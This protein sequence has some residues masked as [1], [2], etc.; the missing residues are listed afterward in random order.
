MSEAVFREITKADKDLLLEGACQLPKALAQMGFTELRKGQEDPIMSILA[1][2][3]T[4]CI[5]PTGTGK[6]A[7]F[8]IPSLCHEWPT[9]VLSPLVALMRDQVKSLWAKGIAGGALSGIQTPAENASTLKAWMDGEVQFLYVAP[10]RL[11]NEQFRQA[12][13]ARPPVHVVVDEAHTIT[14]W[15]DN[16]RPAY[17]KAGDFISEHNPRVVSAFTATCPAEVEVDIR[18]VL[19]IPNAKRCMY[20]PRRTNLKLSS[21]EFTGIPQIARLIEKTDGCGI[22]YCSSIKNVEDTAVALQ[23]LLDEDVTLFHAQLP[24]NVRRTNQDLFM[25]GKAKVVVA[26]NAFGMGI[27]KPD[28]RFVIHRDIPGSLESL[29]Q[30]VGRAGR[31]GK[32][33]WCCTLMSAQGRRIQEYFLDG[34]NPDKDTITKVYNVLKSRA[35]GGGKVMLTIEEIGKIAGVNSM[36][37]GSSLSALSGAGCIKREATDEKIGMIKILKPA[38]DDD[39][40]TKALFVE[41]KFVNTCKMIVE[42]GVETT[43]GFIE[44]DLNWICQQ[45]D[46]TLP[47]VTK[48]IK[49]WEKDGLLEYVPPF[50]GSVTFITGGLNQVDFE[51]LKTKARDD[52]HKLNL[53][54]KYLDT[55]DDKKHEFIEKYFEVNR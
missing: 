20:Y 42:G 41:D 6:S 4:L 30:E 27:D 40:E 48:W 29:A 34:N 32:E 43:G 35:D 38:Y 8:T 3:D 51:R 54:Y 18:R 36:Y 49:Q 15:S 47:T 10:E 46:R 33:S 52:Y 9:V 45:T 24:P 19:G 53:I 7:V 23:N 12:M 21:A 2:R 13:R 50:R 16:F 44:I 17:I 55:P 37:V 1:G 14:Q 31:D 25:E 39:E 11:D 26:T 28:I 5:L 22:V